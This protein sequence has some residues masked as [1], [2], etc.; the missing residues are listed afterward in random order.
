M[1][2]HNTRGVHRVRVIEKPARNHDHA[3]EERR[4]KKK[5]RRRNERW[6]VERETGESEKGWKDGSA[7]SRGEGKGTKREVGVGVDRK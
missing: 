1:Y 2:L 4:G 5:R 3:L 7:S 6:T